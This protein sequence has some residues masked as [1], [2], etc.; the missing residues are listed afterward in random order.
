MELIT[1]VARLRFDAR[2]H[3]AYPS[4]FAPKAA[5]RIAENAARLDAD[6][7]SLMNDLLPEMEYESVSND[8]HLD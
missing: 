3:D 7:T 4:P 5:C 8:L 1:K 2:T 6:V